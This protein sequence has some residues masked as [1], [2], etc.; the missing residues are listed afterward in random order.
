[1]ALKIISLTDLINS[2]QTEE[3]IK[4]LL[5]SFETIKSRSESGAR[6]VEEFLHNKAIQFEIMGIART[7]LV[8]STYKKKPLLAGYFALSTRPLIIP[9]RQYSK[10]SKNL[11]KRLMGFGHKTEQDAYEVKGYLL[12]QLGKNYSAD[13]QIAKCVTGQDILHLSYSKVLDA[14]RIVGGRILYLECEHHEK[15]KKF[16][17][18]NGFSELAHYES[19]N[20]L[21]LMVQQIS[22]LQY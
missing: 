22:K 11:Q 21:C 10:I 13:A 18:D 9:K 2:D 12:G 4:K 14:H 7:Y 5:F 1:M 8:M 20:K 3:D 17:N 19:E 6:D 16:Y 15:V